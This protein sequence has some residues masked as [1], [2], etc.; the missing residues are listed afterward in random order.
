MYGA[1]SLEDPMVIRSS[2]LLFFNLGVKSS[3]EDE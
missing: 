2:V 1:E 3:V